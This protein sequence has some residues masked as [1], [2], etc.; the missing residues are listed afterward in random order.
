MLLEVAVTMHQRDRHHGGAGVGCRTQRVAGKHA[1]TARVGRQ[2][3]AEGDFH[4]EVRDL[5]IGKVDGSG[6][7]KTFDGPEAI[8]SLMRN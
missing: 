8:D 6:W 7:R 1:E 3:F 2:I 4:G 5:A